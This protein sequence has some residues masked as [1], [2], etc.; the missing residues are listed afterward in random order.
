MSINKLARRIAIVTAIAAGFVGASAQAATV[1]SGWEGFNFDG[2]GSTGTLTF[3]TSQAALFNI[4]DLYLSGDVFG[5]TIDGVA[6]GN[7]SAVSGVDTSTGDP[8]FAFTS[9][10]FSHGSYLVGIGSHEVD[11]TMVASPYGG[12]GADYELVAAPVPESSNLALMGLGLAAVALRAR[13]A[14]K[15]G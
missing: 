14:A 1:G 8:D 2:Q 13:R 5:L 12:G 9:P 3:T 10:D 6:V 15:R 11:F 4:T 7:T